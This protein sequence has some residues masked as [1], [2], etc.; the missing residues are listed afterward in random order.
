M[1][2]FHGPWEHA[3]IRYGSRWDASAGV[4]WG[5]PRM[6]SR[7]GGMPRFTP[8]HPWDFESI[9]VHSMLRYQLARIKACLVSPHGAKT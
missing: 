3:S 4:F 9:P 5:I 7:K 2:D 1:Q 8:L 6:L